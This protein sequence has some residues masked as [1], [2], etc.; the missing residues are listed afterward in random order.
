MINYG[1]ENELRPLLLADEKLIWTGKPKTGIVFRNSDVFLI[2]FSLFW[3][4]FAVFWETSVLATGA[5]LPFA[6][7]GIPFIVVGLYITVGRFFLDARKRARTIYGITNDRIIISTGIFSTEVKSLN[8]RTL[9]DITISQKADYS[10][11]ITLGPTDL[12]TTMLRGM[13]WPGIKQAPRLEC[14]EDVKS[15]YDKIIALQRQK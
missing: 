15:V 14:I 3:A 6:L 5:P 9:S 1:I 8:I 2:P 7:F 4:G 13:E 12:S 10:G 11:S